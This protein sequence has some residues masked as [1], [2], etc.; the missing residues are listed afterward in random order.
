MAYTHTHSAHTHRLLNASH[1]LSRP[2]AWTHQARESAI[3]HDFC[4][5][6][7]V[8]ALLLHD[9]CI[10]CMRFFSS[11]LNDH[12]AA[13]C[14]VCYVHYIHGSFLFFFSPLAH[15]FALLHCHVHQ[16]R[17]EIKNNS[18]AQTMEIAI[19]TSTTQTFSTH[20]SII[21]IKYFCNKWH[22]LFSPFYIIAFFTA[23]SFYIWFIRFLFSFVFLCHS[24]FL[25]FVP[26]AHRSFSLFILSFIIPASRSRSIYS[27]QAHKFQTHWCC[28]VDIPLNWFCD[29]TNVVILTHTQNFWKPN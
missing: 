15:W 22:V 6:S 1:S 21:L 13:K 24:L 16:F 29:D 10:S 17:M 20:Y 18:T 9:I 25:F 28:T 12:P 5:F 19:A 7:I 27:I 11:S 2:H 26:T 3:Q 23:Y 8:G 14:N 4:L